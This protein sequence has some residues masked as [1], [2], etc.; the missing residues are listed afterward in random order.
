MMTA[1]AILTDTV[2]RRALRSR[3]V[4][5]G[6]VILGLVFVACLAT[7]PWTLR[8]DGRLAF[9]GQAADRSYLAPGAGGAFGADILG[10][11]LLGRCLLV[12]M[13]WP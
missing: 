6:G 7:M 4:A 13:F 1:P 10:R 8:Q 11:S 9:D 5:I 2:W 12:P 3:R